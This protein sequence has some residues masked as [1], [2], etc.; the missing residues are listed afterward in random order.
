[1]DSGVRQ[2]EQPQITCT[3]CGKRFRYKPELAGRTVQ[4]P[5]GAAIIIPRPRSSQSPDAEDDQGEYDFAAQPETKRPPVGLAA[6]PAAA[7]APATAP[8]APPLPLGHS[9]PPQRKGL[10]PEKRLTNEELQPPST[11]RDLILPSILIP[12]GVVLRFFEVMS[13]SATLTPMEFGPAIAAVGLKLVLS[14][15][16]MLGGMF[17]AVSIMDV[18]FIGS[19]YRI[20]YRL[21]AIAVAPGALYGILTFMGGETY[22]GMIGTFASVAAYTLL[23]WL[24]MRLD[25]KDTSMCVIVTWILV[26][27]ANYIG[28]K[29][30][31]LLR[32]SW[33]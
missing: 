20:A 16:L 19:R 21:I 18:N 1:M 9:L 6:G 32:D 7:D 12:I 8:P 3:T 17:L 23:F 24:L 4:C 5:C 33:I 28:Y 13:P 22:G 14:V 29:A 25:V 30:E 10:T 26:T 11:L 15:C 31:G 2:Q 27:A